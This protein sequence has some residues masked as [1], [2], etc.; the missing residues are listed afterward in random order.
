MG[1]LFTLALLAL[2]LCG[3]LR[4]GFRVARVLALG[5]A[6]FPAGKAVA[7]EH[8]AFSPGG[9]LLATAARDRKVHLWDLATG[10]E[11]FALEGHHSTPT[12]LRFSP[13][14]RIL[15]SAADKLFPQKPQPRP[16]PM[17][18]ATAVPTTPS[19]ARAPQGSD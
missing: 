19:Q 5:L 10:Q 14:G 9:D 2:P 3:R 16:A 13:D 11:L 6:L 1:L 15:A 7:V 12:R 17:P 8:A 18:A 4:A